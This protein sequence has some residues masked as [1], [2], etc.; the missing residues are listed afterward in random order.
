[1]SLASSISES[2]K[3]ADETVPLDWSKMLF[4]RKDPLPPGTMAKLSLS[5][6]A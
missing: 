3:F 1:M 4:V 5:P 6:K 2:K